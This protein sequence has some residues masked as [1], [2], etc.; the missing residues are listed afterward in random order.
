MKQ[1]SSEVRGKSRGGS[2]VARVAREDEAE[3]FDTEMGQRHY[4]GAGRPVGDYLRQIVEVEG[5]RVGLLV[6]GPAWPLDV[7][8]SVR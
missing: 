2:F 4:L 5:R 7:R 8:P 1:P 3:W 6:W